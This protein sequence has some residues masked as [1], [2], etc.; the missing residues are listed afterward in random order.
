MSAGSE[1]IAPRRTEGAVGVDESEVARGCAAAPIA[2]RVPVLCYPL[3]SAST[4][5]IMHKQDRAAHCTA[6]TPMPIW[7]IQR[8]E[9]PI[10]GRQLGPDLIR[11]LR[12]DHAQL[13]EQGE[14]GADLID[15]VRGE[16]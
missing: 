1:A 8:R 13:F 15:E 4:V 16:G 12:L 9:R 6:Q 3:S 5:T 11:V 14:I 10:R 7:S 2:E